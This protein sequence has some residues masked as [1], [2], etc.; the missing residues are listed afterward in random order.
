MSEEERQARASVERRGEEDYWVGEI[1]PARQAFDRAFLAA[2][3]IVVRR[4]LRHWLLVANAS[5]A[6]TVAGA[7]LSPYLMAQG[8]TAAGGALFVVFS[9]ICAQNPDHSYFVLGF[10]MAMDQ[11]M[12]AIYAAATLAGI[13]F[14]P[15]RRRLR[16]LRWQWYL[17]L[18]APMAIDGFT[19]LFG[20]RHSN[21]ELRTATG[22]LFGAASVWWLY[23]LLERELSRI[24]AALA[25]GGRG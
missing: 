6:A 15:L 18:I 8:W 12:T 9:L 21:W 16:A 23:P 5:N 19:Q 25:R 20:W 22:A 4:L 14:V 11:R 10:Q 7:L 2:G 17:V 24:S 1:S 13:A 3:G